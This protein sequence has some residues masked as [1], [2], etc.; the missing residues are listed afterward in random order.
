MDGG[1]TYSY[2]R[3]QERTMDIDSTSAYQ[4]KRR[5]ESLR[6]EIFKVGGGDDLRALDVDQ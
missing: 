6:G 4:L 1:L 2:D 5:D 3:R